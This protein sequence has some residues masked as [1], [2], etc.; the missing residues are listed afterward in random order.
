MNKP[1][2]MIRV[3]TCL[4][5]IL[6][7]CAEVD[8]SNVRI[9]K[10]AK[11]DPNN[12]IAA[13]ADGNVA[14]VEFSIAWDNSWRDDYNWDAVYV[15][16]KF[17][18]KSEIAWQR[19][20]LRDKFHTCTKGY[21][22]TM[23]R[24]T[25]TANQSNGAFIYRGNN[26]SGSDTVDVKLHWM[27][28][29]Q[30]I[31]P[32]DFT[33]GR[34]EYS[35]MCIEMVY[36]PRGPF[37]VGD[38]V[39][40][41]RFR[42]NY[43]EIPEEWDIIKNDGVQQHWAN[44]DR[45]TS[46]YVEYNPDKAANHINA[47][48]RNASLQNSWY[49]YPSDAAATPYWKV[50]FGLGVKKEVKYFGVSGLPGYPAYR[51]TTWK[52]KGS[53]DDTQ[54]IELATGMNMDDWTVEE[55]SYP[56]PKA[57]KVTNSGSYRYYMLE[58][59]KN[60]GYWPIASN[61]A[62]TEKDLEAE[63]AFDSYLITDDL[64][65]MDLRTHLSDGGTGFVN[66]SL[67]ANYPKGYEGFYAMKYEISQ[68]QYVGFLNKLLY[69]QQ[70]N[71]TI[72]A[73]L[74]DLK[75]GDYV[76]PSGLTYRNGIAVGKRD[77]NRI[78]FVNNLKGGDYSQIDDGQTIACNFL[79][80][81]DMLAYADW[82]GLRPLSE[83]EY[84]K[85]NRSLYPNI[86]GDPTADHS[87]RADW[88][89]G[90]SM[91]LPASGTVAD[92][93][94]PNEKLNGANI[95]I[96]NKVAGPVRCGSFADGASTKSK[97]GASE[98][99]VMELSGNLKEIYYNMSVQGQVFR[100]DIVAHGDGDIVAES[101]SNVQ[102]G[103]SNVIAS[104]WPVDPKAFALRGGSFKDKE[105]ERGRISDRMEC[106]A[107]SDIDERKPDVSFRLGHSFTAIDYGSC[108]TY[109]TLPNGRVSSGNLTAYDTVC[110]FQSFTIKGSDLLEST[111]YAG[112]DVK[113]SFTGRCTYY[114]WISENGQT[115]WRYLPGAN[116]KDLTYSLN[117]EA[118]D[119][120]EVHFQRV[121]NTPTLISGT[122]VVTIR[123]M[124]DRYEVSPMK[125]TIT[126]A[127]NALGFLAETRLNASFDWRWK[128]ASG[129]D[130]LK[131]D[132]KAATYDFYVA[133]REDFGYE[134]KKQHTVLCNI[135]IANKCKHQVELKVYVAERPKTGIASNSMS[136]ANCGQ[137]MK[138]TRNDSVYM[139]VKIGNRCWMAENLRYWVDDYT[140]Y[141]P[142][143]PTGEHLGM[144]Y[145]YNAN[146]RDI[147]CPDGWEM[148]SD[149]DFTD[150]N[151][152][153][154]D[155]INPLGPKFKAGNAWGVNSSNKSSRGTNQSGF[156]AVGAN[157]R[158]AN[159]TWY[160]GNITYFISYDNRYWHLEDADHG[161]INGGYAASYAMSLR[162]ILKK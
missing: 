149:Q 77:N 82:A 93:G 1:I 156:G 47:G 102:T 139:T 86:S 42:R 150:L 52:L 21:Q 118:S 116:G 141:S 75:E 137:M 70:K 97:A 51:P 73:A 100:Q 134:A 5:M 108:V 80:V 145:W 68:E 53:N 120:R 35:L 122:N 101:A 65:R 67:Q 155:G 36:I 26:S 128:E 79:S 131:S 125:D 57:I 105:K 90:G 124:D 138:D 14:V 17:K 152:A 96:G 58:M 136:L 119:I 46:H 81:S 34:I 130:S 147:V 92:M 10:D 140:A 91:Q 41:Q 160:Y 60:G 19:V 22:F 8:A 95:N 157:H 142:Y 9:V 83:M 159:G 29:T 55:D 62:M 133:E 98:W 161:L 113:K 13:T 109:L 45:K 24:S 71:R 48:T 15:F 151:N 43:F 112:N 32:S 44:G 6:G 61:I 12:G 50:D 132:T 37:W 106:A 148:P 3:I 115:S 129:N 117:N 135:T 25:T 76:Y 2:N 84:E 107:F 7:L 87:I 31:N 33:G 30:G 63:Y 72:G 54:W 89:G 23:A 64:L 103:C 16:L 104:Y 88:A 78:I 56:V 66:A 4:I 153:V 154:D 74:D 143:D 39:A 162:C 158:A 28:G 99:G 49:S 40:E 111:D 127:N 11:V 110:R 126:I 20:L 38:G 69:N 144:Y 59:E 146:M 27:I 18:R 85:M 94:T 123:V 114:W 121:T